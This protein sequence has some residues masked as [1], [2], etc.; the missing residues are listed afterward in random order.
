M[1]KLKSLCFL[2]MTNRISFDSI[3]NPNLISLTLIHNSNNLD[4]SFLQA[5]TKAFPNLK[6]LNIK[7]SSF[8]HSDALIFLLKQ[9]PQFWQIVDQLTTSYVPVIKVHVTL[10]EFHNPHP[11]AASIAWWTGIADDV[12]LYLASSLT[13]L[14]LINLEFSKLYHSVFVSPVI[15]ESSVNALILANAHCLEYFQLDDHYIPCPQISLIQTLSTC[16]RLIGLSLPHNINLEHF[17]TLLSNCKY[18]KKLSSNFPSK[19]DHTIASTSIE[20]LNLLSGLEE[21]LTTHIVAHF[22]NI[23]HLFSDHIYSFEALELFPH[24]KYV[25]SNNYYQRRKGLKKN[26]FLTIEFISSGF[27]IIPEP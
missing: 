18:L 20:V 16:Q 17:G 10:K 11:R 6:Y 24:L 3:L 23:T 1:S 19:F 21:K 27:K 7:P 12:F 26:H 8:N 15:L 9:Y 5:I 2:M 25:R 13:N 4:L 14:K 22:P